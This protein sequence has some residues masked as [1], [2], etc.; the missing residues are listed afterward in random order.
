MQVVCS[1]NTDYRF[2]TSTPLKRSENN[3]LLDPPS[4]PCIP[5]TLILTEHTD[6][7]KTLEKYVRRRDHKNILYA[8]ESGLKPST[9]ILCLMVQMCHASVVEASIE[10]LEEI[11]VRVLKNA[12]KRQYE[13]L[14]CKIV[15]KVKRIHG[16][17]LEM[18]VEYK[19][20]FLFHAL[21]HN[22]DPN[23]PLK[24]GERLIEK[25]YRKRKYQSVYVLL[26]TKC[27]E[28]PDTLM[29]KLLRHVEYIPLCLQ[30]GAKASPQFIITALE[31]NNKGMLLEVAS[32]LENQ[33]ASQ[34]AWDTIK[35]TLT[36]PITAEWTTNLVRT[37]AGHYYDRDAIRRWVMEHNNDPMTRQE[38]QTHD[39]QE[40]VRCL[41]ELKSSLQTLIQQLVTQ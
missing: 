21:Q 4:S 8:V 18:F 37:P 29:N 35:D 41:P 3:V 39:L 15:P 22:L 19:A 24:N 13:P 27:I 32:H 40:R 28:I 26:H 20:Q 30:H 31:L 36:C 17:I 6:T 33:Y 10:A 14:F 5:K 23:T 25:C 1:Q 12:M 16:S 7:L 38:I 11:D 34:K 2:H 9:D